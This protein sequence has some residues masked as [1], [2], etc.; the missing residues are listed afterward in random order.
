[1]TPKHIVLA[2]GMSGFPEVPRFPG[3][4]LF[5]GTQ[6]HSS[7]H[8]G[9]EGWAGKRCVVV[10]SNNSAHDIAADLWEHG[11]DVTLLQRSP[12]LVMRAETLAKNR[13][14]YSEA[15]LAGGRRAR[16][17]AGG[18]GGGGGGSRSVSWSN[19]ANVRLRSS[20]M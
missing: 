16:P 12:T 7:R 18:G 11:A 1:M 8:A 19:S 17:A 20:L 6:H 14:L 10:G 2:T 4:D 15:A 13:A 5:K 9:G 3:A